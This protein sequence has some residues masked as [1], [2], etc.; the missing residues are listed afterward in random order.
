M[1]TK[2]KRVTSL[3]LAMLLVLTSL[4]YLDQ[5]V[6]AKEEVDYQVTIEVLRELEAEGIEFDVDDSSN[7]QLSMTYTIVPKP[8][9]VTELES[10]SSTKDIVVVVDTSSDMGLTVDGL[11]PSDG[12]SSRMELA[13]EALTM[14]IGG[15]SETPNTNMGIITFDEKAKKVTYGDDFLLDLSSSDNVSY[16]QNKVVSLEP[17]SLDGLESQANNL[18]DAIQQAA[19]VLKDSSSDEQ[20]LVVLTNDEANAFSYSEIDSQYN[21][22]DDDDESETEIGYIYEESR[23]LVT[24][25]DMDSKDYILDGSAIDQCYVNFSDTGDYKGYVKKYVDKAADKVDKDTQSYLL[26]FADTEAFSQVEDLA[27]DIDGESFTPNS[28]S[29]LYEDFSYIANEINGEFTIDEISFTDVLP[30][31]IEFVSGPSNMSIDHSVLTMDLQNISYSK[32]DAYYVADSVSFTI[33]FE[34]ENVGQYIFGD[35][36]VSVMY[37]TDLDGKDRKVY[38]NESYLQVVE[39][40]DGSSD[41]EVLELQP[42]REFELKLAELKTEFPGYN[43]ILSQVSI[44]EFDGM[45]DDANGN[46][47]IIYIGDKEDYDDLKIKGASTEVKVDVDMSTKRAKIISDFAKA[48][49]LLTI[50]EDVFDYTDKDLIS[51]LEQVDHLDNVKLVKDG[52]KDNLTENLLDWY[53]ETAHRPTLTFN[54]MPIEYDGLDTSYLADHSMVYSFDAYNENSGP[55]TAK[56]YIDYNGDGIFSDYELAV[57]KEVSKNLGKV[58]MYYEVPEFFNGLMPWKFDLIED[59]TG[60]KDTEVGFTAMHGDLT[61]VRVLNLVPDDNSLKFNSSSFIPPLST[62]NYEIE[63]IRMKVSDFDNNYPNEVDGNPTLLNGNYDMILFGFGDS[64]R[65]KDIVRTETLTAIDD[66][67]VT[68]QSIMFTHDLAGP[69]DY[70]NNFDMRTDTESYND[71][72]SYNDAPVITA[73][74]KDDMGFSNNRTYAGRKTWRAWGTNVSYKQN[75]GVITKYPYILADNDDKTLP[76]ATTHDQYWEIDLE[77]ENVVPWFN[78]NCGDYKYYPAAYYYTFTNNNITYSGTGHSNPSGEWEQKLF[79]NTMLKAARTANHAPTFRLEK[80]YNGMNVPFSATSIDLAVEISDIDF[81]DKDFVTEFYYII[82]REVDDDGN[83]TSEGTRELVKTRSDILKDELT[84]VTLAKTFDQSVDEVILEVVVTDQ[85]GAF[86]SQEVE[87]THNDDAGLVVDV[88]TQGALVGDTINVSIDVDGAHPEDTELIKDIKIGAVINT[89]IA[90]VTDYTG[91]TRSGYTYTMRPEFDD[92]DTTDDETDTDRNLKLKADSVGEYT[93]DFD[94]TFGLRADPDSDTYETKSVHQSASIDVKSG[95]ISV[96]IED[97]IG[98]VI[99]GVTVTVEKSAVSK[100][101]AVNGAEHKS[102]DLSSGSYDVKIE[103][104]GNGYYS[105]V[106]PLEY[107]VNLSYSNP[108]ETIYFEAKDTV[109]PEISA[110][111]NRQLVVKPSTIDVHIKFDGVNSKLIDYDIKKLP[112]GTTTMTK[113][114]YFASTTL[115]TV[116]YTLD[117]GSPFTETESD[118]IALRNFTVAENGYYVLYAK[119]EAGNDEIYIIEINNIVEVDTDII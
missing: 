44:T 45:I 12:D 84:D 15:V 105:A 76:I 59:L 77:N 16:I 20:Y 50:D 90:H 115:D 116:I 107:T 21:D 63:V 101:V 10:F 56:L 118:E 65:N 46:Y 23:S 78:L 2:M 40:L 71:Y 54:S 8:I 28:E 72:V 87:L 38:F 37:Y 75:E 22:G 70:V 86:T 41:L 91:F 99:P 49:Q 92:P 104:P 80:V 112:V 11:E 94:G 9:P 32:D 61:T 35:D 31:D 33:W 60:A 81:F 106:D 111:F 68:G 117:T 7:N 108:T 5:P 96:I 98:R 3:I 74:F 102:S 39:K 30:E 42:G 85:H 119:N 1:N 29:E 43:V 27:S 26:G 114:E 14:F 109:P 57:E 36:E 19:K 55:M 73:N 53:D 34:V 13:K 95:K 51:Q 67:I 69:Q 88:N 64:Y 93:I 62:T 48:G 18:G 79:V 17:Q 83:I 82:G 25:I 103:L 24:D 100:T 89:G 66:F 113:A 110:D 4:Y 6:Y 47:D 97:N 52:K 58:S